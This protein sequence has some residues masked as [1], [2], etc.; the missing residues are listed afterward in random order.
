[1]TF[2]KEEKNEIKKSLNVVLDDI[3][4]LWNI[5]QPDE[6]SISLEGDLENWR[7]KIGREKVKLERFWYDDIDRIYFERPGISKPNRTPS[8][9]EVAMVFVSNYEEIRKKIEQEIKDKTKGK[10]FFFQK[11][12]EVD[13]KFNK[14]ADIEIDAPPT[15]NLQEL[16][17]TTTKDGNKVLTINFGERTIRLIT[18]GGFVLVDKSKTT[19]QTEQTEIKPEENKRKSKKL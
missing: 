3:R 19:T 12:K 4:E 13:M 9:Y 14:Y 6:V 10:E 7:L 2:T 15:N 16:E 5:S 17:V 11:L 1:M 18:N 8:N